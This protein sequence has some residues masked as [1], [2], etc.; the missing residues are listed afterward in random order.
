MIKTDNIF[1]LM[2]LNSI[3]GGRK[4]PHKQLCAL[5]SDRQKCSGEKVKRVTET[6]NRR[7]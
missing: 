6:E 7:D 5:L 2:E 3:W 1:D 4:K